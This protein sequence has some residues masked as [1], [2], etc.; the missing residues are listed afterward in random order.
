MDFPCG[1]VDRNPPANAGG[2]CW[3]PCLGGYHMPQGNLAHVSQLLSLCS[4][5]PEL[6]LLSRRTATAEACVPGACALQLE[7]PP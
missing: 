4:G 7:K 5:S 6:Q 3:I 1:S 2:T